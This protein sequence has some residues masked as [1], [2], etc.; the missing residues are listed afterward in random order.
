MRFRAGIFILLAFLIAGAGVFILIRG[1][2]SVTDEAIAEKT[3]TSTPVENPSAVDSSAADVDIVY[4]FM[5]TQ[6]CPSCMR[7]E[8]FTRETVQTKFGD[9]LAEGR[10]LWRMVNVDHPENEHFVKDYQLYTKSVVLVKIRKGK[11]VEWKNLDRVWQLL[12]SK[13]AF[14]TYI[15]D[16]VK[17]FVEKG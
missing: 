7:I 15:A 13:S 10:I 5:T 9:A 17:T 12:Q 6:R 4:Y 1:K 11:Q 8:T 16:E 14:Q 3:K 2:K